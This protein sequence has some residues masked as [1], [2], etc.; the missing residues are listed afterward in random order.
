MSRHSSCQTT[1]TGLLERYLSARS[2]PLTA[3]TFQVSTDNSGVPPAFVSRSLIH[4]TP[5]PLPSPHPYSVHRAT[6]VQSPYAAK[7]AV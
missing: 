1:S 2:R 3:I 5:A 6:S 7:P 4:A